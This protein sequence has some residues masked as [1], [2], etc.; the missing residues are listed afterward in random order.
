L[1]SVPEARDLLRLATMPVTAAARQFGHAWFPVAVLPARP[2]RSC[3]SWTLCGACTKCMIA[4]GAE[5][6][7]DQPGYAPYDRTH[8]EL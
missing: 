6:G 1:V 5:I 4:C 3:S 7:W 8:A 2:R